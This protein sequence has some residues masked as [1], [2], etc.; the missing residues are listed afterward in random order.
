MD[1]DPRERT[2]LR[3]Y[4]IW[5]REGRSGDPAS[6]WAQ[7]EQELA[8]E[9]QHDLG[10]RDSLPEHWATAIE[11]TVEKLCRGARVR[12]PRRPQN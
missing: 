4:Q 10:Q 9:A 1:E 7:A 6:H 5:E 2:R 11:L 8:S 12:S 3:A